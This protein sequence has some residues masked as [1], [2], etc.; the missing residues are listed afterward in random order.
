M[1]RS[2]IY[3]FTLILIILPACSDGA[4]GWKTFKGSNS[5]PLT[6]E[7]PA[8]LKEIEPT[9]KDIS[10]M[11]TDGEIT[12]SLT[13]DEFPVNAPS[14]SQFSEILVETYK[15]QSSSIGI[16]GYEKIS[17]E[18]KL[19]NDSL[20]AGILKSTFQLD[21]TGEDVLSTIYMIP[22]GPKMYGVAINIPKK[23]Y[24]SRK[25][26]IDRIIKSVKITK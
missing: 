20:K 19:Y 12:L 21:Q 8:N 15:S 10:S 2:V 7:H 23:S 13:I 25:A 18:E 14:A 6:F 22:Y 24:E 17:F 16:S 3:L 9:N 1:K 5:V 26:D 4:D 11:F